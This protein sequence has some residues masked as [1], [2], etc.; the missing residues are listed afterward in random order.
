MNKRMNISMQPKMRKH[1]AD[2][3]IVHHH[4]NKKKSFNKII[5]KSDKFY[6][7]VYNIVLLR[8][9]ITKLNNKLKFTNI[10]RNPKNYFEIFFKLFSTFRYVRVG[11]TSR[12]TLLKLT[13]FDKSLKRAF[14]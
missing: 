8:K 10:F 5:Y 9:K 3:V 14:A 1:H 2:T 4:P 11:I 6:L 12:Q 13:L 7:K